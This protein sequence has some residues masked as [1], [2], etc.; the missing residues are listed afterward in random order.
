MGW[1]SGEVCVWDER[2]SSLHEPQTQHKRAVARLLWN[3]AGTRLVSIDAVGTCIGWKAA[4]VANGGVSFATA[5]YHELR[6]SLVDL[7]FRDHRRRRTP[8]RNL[9]H[10]GDEEEVSLASN[11]GNEMSF[12]LTD[13]EATSNDFYV[14]S[15]TGVIY[16]VSENGSCGDVYQMDAGVAR[17]LHDVSRDA[18]VVVTDT[19]TLA[20]FAIGDDGSLSEQ[21]RF[22]VS[23]HGSDMAV[24]WVAVQTESSASR[25]VKPARGLWRSSVVSNRRCIRKDFD[26]RHEP[27]PCRRVDVDRKHREQHTLENPSWPPVY[28]VPCENW[29]G[30]ILTGSPAR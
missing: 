8:N 4:K 12:G 16:F 19:L 22:K 1:D 15:T 2:Q 7:A 30:L 24:T 20:Q 26:R 27:R 11:W 21:S 10:G 25:P 13:D 3:G 17:L 28:V 18:L 14:G 6:D 29:R 23:G 9:E 5:F